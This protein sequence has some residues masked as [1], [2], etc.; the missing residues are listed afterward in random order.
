MRE[1][2]RELG[3]G[4]V[5]SPELAR[6]LD[7]QLVDV[8]EVE[9]QVFW[10]PTGDPAAPYRIDLALFEELRALLQHRVVHSIAFPV[11]NSRPHDAAGLAAL[12]RSVV[13]LDAPYASEHLSFDTFEDGG[14][15][16]W[17]GFFL[18]P[19]QTAAGV[20]TAAARLD[21]MRRAL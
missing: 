15:A 13:A 19:R 1:Q 7:L 20:Q 9:P 16:V 8:L 4:V 21:E 6:V 5:Y 10:R 18:P 14:N 3:I 11:G 17:T 2:P 12:A